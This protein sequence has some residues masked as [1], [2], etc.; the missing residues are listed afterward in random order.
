MAFVEYARPGFLFSF[1]KGAKCLGLTCT[2]N[3]SLFVH[4][5]EA[6]TVLRTY[7]IK[8]IAI[9]FVISLCF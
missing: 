1:A 6:S 3:V 4:S 8:N 2:M 9:L 5:F 7:Q